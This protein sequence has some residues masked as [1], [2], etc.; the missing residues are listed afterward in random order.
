M[1]IVN[2]QSFRTRLTKEHEDKKAK[3]IKEQKR[4]RAIVK[5]LTTLNANTNMRQQNIVLSILRA[6]PELIGMRN[7][8]FC[9]PHMMP[10][11]YIY[12]YVYI[13]IYIIPLIRSVLG[14]HELF[15]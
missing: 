4:N 9:Y 7:L 5:L 6:C 14:F 13:Y 2:K 15:T 1:Q 10:Y 8:N 12:I 3:E 11:R